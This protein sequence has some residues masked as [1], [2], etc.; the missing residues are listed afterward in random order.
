MT[1]WGLIEDIRVP[2]GMG[3]GFQPQTLERYKRVHKR[4]D[5]GV[6]KMFLMGV[7]TRKVGDVLKAL[8]NYTLSASYVSKLAKKLDEEVYPFVAHQLCWAHKLR[9]VANKCPKKYLEQCIAHARRI[10]LSRTPKIALRVFREWERTWRDKAPKAVQC[11]A[12]DIDKHL[13]FLNCPVEHHKI[14][15]TTNV[16]ERL[17]RELRRRIKVMGTFS[18]TPSCKRIVHSLFAY[19]NTRWTRISY[20]I[21]EIALNQKQ[22]A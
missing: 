1:T 14:I 5:E 9:N 20:R 2:R 7:S 6:L 12:N 17:F 8:F 21:E 3:N 10:Y 15:R 22:A 11:L 18:D 16:I 19:H 13:A 4:V